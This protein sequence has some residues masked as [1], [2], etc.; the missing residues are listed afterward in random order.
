M[1]QRT[2]MMGLRTLALVAAV[3]FAGTLMPTQISAAASEGKTRTYYIAAVEVNWDY[4]PT[5]RNEAMGMPFDET[6]KPYVEAAAHRIGR[7]YK[8]VMYKEFTDETFTAQKVRPP[9]EQYLGIL[10]P[11]LR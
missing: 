11:I 5:G 6:E 10:G 7:V 9:E 4:A 2:F 1:A 8:K 3:L